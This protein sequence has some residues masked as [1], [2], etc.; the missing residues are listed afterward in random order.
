MIHRRN[1]LRPSNF[2][3]LGL[4]RALGDRLVPFLVAAMAFLAALA[5]GGASGASGLAA[6]WRGG[7]AASVTVQVPRP[8]APADGAAGGQ[9][10]QEAVLALLRGT[11]GVASARA[12][13]DEDLA[14]LLRPWLGGGL[15]QVSLPLPAVIDLRLAESGPAALDPLAARAAAAAPGTLMESHGLWAGRLTVLADSLRACAALA[16]AVVAAVAAAVVSVAVRAGLLARRVSIEI[17]H[18]LGASD[19]YISGRFAARAASLSGAGGAIGALAA[20]PVLVFMANLTTP[21]ANDPSVAPRAGLA[22]LPAALWLVA[23]GLPLASGAIGWLTAQ[24][25]VRRW[26]RRLA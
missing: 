17:V 10:R 25:T 3:E 14:E 6:R 5:L 16:L 4:R 15:Q 11:P 19:S 23:P 13:S 12:L 20:L 1:L 24:L 9:T 8:R 7:A 22:A 2:D 21:F 26:L 18:S